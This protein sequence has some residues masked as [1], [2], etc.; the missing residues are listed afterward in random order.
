MSFKQDLSVKQYYYKGYDVTEHY[1]AMKSGYLA[2]QVRN[3]DQFESYGYALGRF[4]GF[5]A[6]IEADA[7]LQSE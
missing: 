3:G 7:P 5:L 4:I 1:F 2:G 6:K